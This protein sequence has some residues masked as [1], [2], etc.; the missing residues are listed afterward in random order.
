MASLCPHLNR[1]ILD[2]GKRCPSADLIPLL[3]ISEP[4]LNIDNPSFREEPSPRPTPVL[5]H[6]QDPASVGIAWG[7]GLASASVVAASLAGR[8]LSVMVAQLGQT[9]EEVF[10]GDRLPLLKTPMDSGD[11]GMVPGM[12]PG[13]HSDTASGMTSEASSAEP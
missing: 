11:P 5:G 6:R 3:K 2:M 12:T 4:M 1:F 10:R 9:S 7:V 8:W 13:M